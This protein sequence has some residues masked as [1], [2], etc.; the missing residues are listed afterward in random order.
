MPTVQD[1]AAYAETSAK[2]LGIHKYDVYGSSVDETSVQVDK[3][4]PKQVKA[5][6][7]SSV[8]VRVW[9]DQGLLGVTSTTDVD[10]AG[11]E[12]ALKTAQ[13][14]AAF[15]AKENIPDFSPEAT[16]PTTEVQVDNLPP[17]PVSDLIEGLVGLEKRLLEAH[18]A[19]ASVPYNGLAQRDIDRFY[20]NSEGALRHENRSYASVYL[21]SKTEQEGRKPRSAGAMRIN[22]GLQNLD[23]EGCLKE[24]TEKTLSHLD[25]QKI[26]TGKYRIVFSAEAFLSLL[27]AFS[28]LYNAQS[29]LDR[30][31]L[32]TPESLGTQIAS[33]LLSV[34]DDAL[35]PE[36]IGAETFDGE[37]TPTRRVPI[38][39]EGVLTQFLHS[40]GTAKRMGASPT[41]HAD[42]GAKVS[43]SP[44]FYHVMPGQSDS[45]GFSLETADNVILIDDLQALHA[46]VNALQG[47]F[48]LPFDGWLIRQGE[49]IS[50]ESAT[51][52]GDFREVL[53]SIIHVEPEAE[54]T[55]GGIC[56][57]IWVDELSVTGEA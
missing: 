22:R 21:Y 12:L 40:A 36:N 32:A 38:I 37:G 33:S 8:I 20:L 30:R 34:F 9:S 39:A 49:R 41:G 5:S 44:S 23:L 3:G 53:K 27:G 6:N 17:A 35:H 2:K 16:V 45:N 1:I 56:P 43:I 13:E 10:P 7:R 29:I 14:A 15:G 51:V 54:V 52:A 42:I 11:L 26:A 24:A 57:R 4:E 55:P 31:S 48:S 25:Y 47:S 46:G 18:P 28:N 50:I 19:I